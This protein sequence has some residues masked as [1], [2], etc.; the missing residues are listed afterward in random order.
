MPEFKMPLSQQ[1]PDNRL[2]LILWQMIVMLLGLALAAYTA[3]TPDLEFRK[4]L[5]YFS[6]VIMIGDLV[7]FPYY[8]LRSGFR[9]V[10]YGLEFVLSDEDLTRK[11]VGWPDIRIELSE[12]KALY[13]RPSWLIVR[14]NDPKRRIGIPREVEGYDELRTAL[15]KHAPFSGPVK[16]RPTASFLTGWVLTLISVLSWWLVSWSKNATVIRISGT[17]ALLWLTWS[18][19]YLDRLF[20]DSAKRPLLW[21]FLGIGW[22]VGLFLIGIRILR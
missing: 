22:M 11:R 7:I 18:S 2:R 13:E 4:P 10:K 15:A 6:V 8:G 21:L 1:G 16:R 3:L 14:S 12:I 19:L 20:R 17:V 5:F 9:R